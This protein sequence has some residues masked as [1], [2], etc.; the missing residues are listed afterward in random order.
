M[1]DAEERYRS[2]WDAYWSSLSGASGE[3]FWDSDPEVAAA[4]DLAPFEALADP[5]LPLVDVGCGNGTQTRYLA[6][7]FSR[8]IGLDVSSKAIELARRTHSAAGLEFRTFDVLRP[9]EAAILHDEI[10]DANLYIRTVLH[11]ILPQHRPPAARSVRTLLGARGTLFLVELAPSA[12]RYFR[13]L[14]ATYGALPPGLARVLSHGITPGTFSDEDR[15]ALFPEDQI[16]R[17]AEGE[18]T[19]ITTYPLPE[20][21][22]AEVPTRFQVLRPRR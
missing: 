22:F 8:V 21:G 4:R 13:S 9:E 7:H 20:G 16:E 2:T 14:A 1:S 18:G 11:Q 10:G 17:L 12:E 6:D 5:A 3:V 19:L 15:A